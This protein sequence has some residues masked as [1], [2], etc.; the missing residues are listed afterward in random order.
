MWRVVINRII[1]LTFLGIISFPT[2]AFARTFNS[3][4]SMK[5]GEYKYVE[6]PDKTFTEYYQDAKGVPTRGSTY[7]NQGM[8]EADRM[9][10]EVQVDS[11]TTGQ[12]A[13]AVGGADGTNEYA[14]E[15]A[16]ED[17]RTGKPYLTPGEA[18]VGNEIADGAVEDGLLPS[19]AD[20]APALSGAIEITGT[21]AVG[22]AIGD[23]L[24]ELL[25][26]P[27]LGEHTGG[28]KGE[29]VKEN[30]Y[31]IWGHEIVFG[32]SEP[33]SVMNARF[34][35]G[36][37]FFGVVE[38]RLLTE[39]SASE[40]ENEI[41]IQTGMP[42][43]TY[44]EVEEFGKWSEPAVLHEQ[45]IEGGAWSGSANYWEGLECPIVWTECLLYNNKVKGEETGSIFTYFSLFSRGGLHRDAF[46][47][48]G[49][50]SY[51]RNGKGASKSLEP[52]VPV[53]T[54]I[55]PPLPLEV[56]APAKHFIIEKGKEKEG[57]PVVTPI[58]DP[59]PEE[60]PIPSPLLP[61]IPEPGHDE[62]ATEYKSKVESDGFTNVEIRTRSEIDTDP[63]EGPSDV[64]K[65]N[66]EPGTRADPSTNIDIE[67]NP[68]TSSVPPPEPPGGIGPPTEPGFHLPNL[69]V[70]CK[71][72]PFG[73][74]CW[75]WETVESW[76]A[77]AVAPEWGIGGWEIAGHKIPDTKYK[78]SSLEP[79]M[80]KVRPA[81]IIFATIGIVL[82]FYQ[83]AKGGGPPSGGGADSGGGGSAPDASTPDEDVYL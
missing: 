2:L 78:L 53:T 55:A 3:P 29:I 17:I 30:F 60:K 43:V 57:K 12:N 77:S 13:A 18:E 56:P 37:A 31:T 81:I 54:P 7:S 32:K 68:G 61:E 67:A 19:L 9:I 80:E 24:D 58:E 74:P 14:A 79:V 52:L 45:G 41:C 42:L 63:T 10:R 39:M 40:Y 11:G 50:K 48:S 49:L 26:L 71:G 69:G 27:S 25:G 21:F 35:L 62:L 51:E 22:V 33:C 36:D 75:L 66:P 83:F 76:S 65:V 20:L 6:N 72:F 15:R 28:S 82:L 16:L 8:A 70:L 47:S 46:P 4:G 5:P 23:G 34:S 44:Y 73:V 1:F 38:S 64:V 59:S